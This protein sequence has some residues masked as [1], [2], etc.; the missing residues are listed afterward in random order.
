MEKF[1]VEA[2][3]EIPTL[4]L[5]ICGHSL[6]GALAAMCGAFLTIP[7]QNKPTTPIKI[8]AIYT[9]GQP[10]VGNRAFIA[11]MNTTNCFRIINFTDPVPKVGYGSHFGREIYINSK[12]KLTETVMKSKKIIDSAKG[13][14]NAVGRA[15]I[16][17]ILNNHTAGEYRY[18]SFYFIL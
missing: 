18:V 15:D 8:S 6:G 11:A 16:G 13:H 17:A 2:L 4:K 10:K 9:I 5:Y 3:K 14:L 7:L 12:G 1:I